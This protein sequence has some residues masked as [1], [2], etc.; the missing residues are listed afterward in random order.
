MRHTE[1]APRIAYDSRGT[2]GPRV[3]MVMG[4][5]M[6]GAVWQP[7][8][9]GLAENHQLA[10]LDN[11][12]IGQS[13]V[14]S[15]PF[16]VRDL[17]QDVLRVA[18]ALGWGSFHLVG[19][20]FGGMISQEVALAAPSRVQ[21]LTLIATHPGGPLGLAPTRSG[22]PK[23]LRSAVGPKRERP[24]YLAKLL[25]T[26]SFLDAVDASVLEGRLRL[27]MESIPSTRTSLMQLLA[28]ARHDTRKR[29]AEI[30]VPTLVIKPD[31]DELVRPFH[32]DR[33]HRGI[34]GARLVTIADAGHGLTFQHAERVNAAIA[35]HVAMHD[36][37][38]AP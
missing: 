32:S 24:E 29:L 31:R 1:S 20:S 36:R 25:Y 3:L 18:D 38:S 33:L 26:E 35:E 10:W 19:V 13:E 15:R 37:A 34:P 7:Q 5:G 4:L 16:H 6:R 2:K 11:R 23:W 14:P 27:Q 12:G 22:F 9:D 21:S 28:V 17:A 30:V 8:I